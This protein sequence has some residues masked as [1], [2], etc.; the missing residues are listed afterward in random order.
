MEL[1]KDLMQSETVLNFGALE[2]RE[3]EVMYSK[4][5]ISSLIKLGWNPMFNLEE[6]LKEYIM[7]NSI[8]EN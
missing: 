1:I 2:Y 5:D 4:A 8:N 7:S 3:N 6:G